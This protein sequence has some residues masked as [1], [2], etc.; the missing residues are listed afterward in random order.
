MNMSSHVW[1]C[2]SIPQWW[3]C[4]EFSIQTHRAP[5][6]LLWTWTRPWATRCDVGVGSALSGVGAA[7]QA[8]DLSCA[9]GLCWCPQSQVPWLVLIGLVWSLECPLG[10]MSQL[11]WCKE[12][13]VR[14]LSWFSPSD[15]LGLR[16]LL[17]LE[18]GQPSEW[19]SHLCRGLFEEAVGMWWNGLWGLCSMTFGV[20]GTESH[21]Q[22]S[23]S[24]Q[25]LCPQDFLQSGLSQTWHCWWLRC[26]PSPVLGHQGHSSQQFVLAWLSKAAV[27]PGS[28]SPAQAGLGKLLSHCQTNLVFCKCEWIHRVCACRS[29]RL[30]TLRWDPQGDTPALLLPD[31]LTLSLRKASQAFHLG[32]AVQSPDPQF[33]VFCIYW[34]CES[35][36]ESLPPSPCCL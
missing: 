15:W 21:L 34:S 26:S 8:S 35:W 18:Q 32:T 13:L 5:K 10:L 6:I 1:E 24:G 7:L 33:E 30:R 4:L 27:C 29:W 19:R 23:W 3:C 11:V 20:D 12:K 9:L 22:Q 14:T 28:V 17:L 31:V 2:V 16:D 36:L 25:L